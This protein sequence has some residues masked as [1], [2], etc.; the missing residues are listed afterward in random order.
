MRKIIFGPPGTGKTTHLLRIVEEELK[1]KVSPNRIGYFAFTTRASEEALKR[2][3][4]DFNHNIKDF[5]YFRTLHSFAYKELYLKEEDVM[6]DDDYDY[7]SN[8]MQIKLSNPN[9]KIK[10]YGAGLPDDIFMRI[11]DLS[12]INGIT[13]HEQF[14]NPE[15][16]HLPGGW[17]KLDYIERALREYKFG[18]KFPRRKYDYTDMLIEFNK[19]NIDD[20]PQFDVVIIDE[21]QDLSWLQ[22]QMV[23]RIAERTQRLYIAGDDDQAIFKWA[24]ARPEFL[25]N[26][27][28]TRKILNKSY[29]LPF[30]IHKKA[31][32]LIRRIKTRVDKKWSSRDAQGEINYYPS[33]QLNKLMQGD[34]LIMARNKY[35]LDLLEEELKLEGY[36]YQRNGSTSVDAKAI[37]AIQ[38]WEKI[39]K[40][41]ELFL[42]EVKNFYY[43]LM[44]DKS[45]NRG[46]KTMQKA[47]REKLYNYDTLTKEHGLNVSSHFPWFEAFDNM[48]R[49]KSTYIRAVLRRGQKI[50]HDPRIKLSTIHGAKGSEADNVMLLTDLSKKTDE[51]YWLNKDEERRVCYVGMTRA[52]Q[53]LNIIRSKSNREF[54]EAF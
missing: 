11:I 18:G 53:S 40:G 5:T 54:T 47:D 35:N 12:K 17:L 41:G 10:T 1:N 4:T 33:E 30:L 42:K 36:Y 38:A 21:A 2:A 50:T 39:R 48:P 52:K 49:L 34:W 13:A 25:I 15:T 6:N 37:R 43:Y 28:G 22:W 31:N 19:K 44:V 24:G 14:N 29:R 27:E 9:K 16:G 51:S 26:M 3:A 32:S 46:H 20:L 8:K 23:E 7:L 45:V